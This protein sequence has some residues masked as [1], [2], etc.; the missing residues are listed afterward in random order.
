[1]G[2]ILDALRKAEKDPTQKSPGPTALPQRSYAEDDSEATA[3]RLA[4]GIVPGVAGREILLNP[5]SPTSESYRK[6]ALKIRSEL[7]TRGA[8][9][10]AITGPLRSEGKTTTACNLALA[11]ASMS[12][13]RRIALVCLDL[14]R[15][16]VASNFGVTPTI[17]IDQ[18]LLDPNQ[19]LSSARLTT[20]VDGLDV[21]VPLKAHE[22]S[23]S[24]LGQERFKQVLGELEQRYDIVILD[25][26]P[27]LLVPDAV[28]ISEQAG[29]WTIVVRQGKTRTASLEDALRELPAE[30]FLGAILNEGSLP[31]KKQDYGYY[32]MSEEDEEES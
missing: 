2:E 29:A 30:K 13:E 3:T 7:D 23:H 21:Y 22:E 25:T 17:G 12:G 31:G 16:S 18:V 27:I 19:T 5:S 32:M 24:I 10:L 28:I 14:R 9:S 26:P 8:R 15:P 6:L 1:M 4:R 11:L 20:D